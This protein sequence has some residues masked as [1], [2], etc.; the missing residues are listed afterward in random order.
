MALEYELEVSGLQEYLSP[1]KQCL[2]C[3]RY[4]TSQCCDCGLSVS[5]ALNVCV[6]GYKCQSTQRVN[7]EVLRHD[8]KY[9]TLMD[10]YTGFFHSG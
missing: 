5:Y 7:L 6:L 10:H 9:F 4:I 8:T 3:S 2:Y 1:G